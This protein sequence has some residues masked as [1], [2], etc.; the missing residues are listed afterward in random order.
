MRGCIGKQSALVEGTAI[1][2]RII[3]KFKV[4][5]PAGQEETWKLR[6]GES[7]I[8]RRERIYMVSRMRKICYYY[9][10]VLSD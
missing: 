10:Y 3:A 8:E 6:A 4:E 5:P 9:F 7:E 2:A 1:L